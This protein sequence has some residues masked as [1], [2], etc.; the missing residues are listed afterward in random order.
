MPAASSGLRQIQHRTPIGGQYRVPR[1]RLT[2]GAELGILTGLPIHSGGDVMS[3]RWCKMHTTMRA[4]V[5]VRAGGPEVLEVRELP[6]PAVREGWSLVQ[7]EGRGL[8]PVG[9]E[10]PSGAFPKRYV[11]ACTW[12]KSGSMSKSCST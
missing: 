4:A 9:A 5:C 12:D 1:C 3:P 11:A 7:G 10:D 8:E 2:L 6:V